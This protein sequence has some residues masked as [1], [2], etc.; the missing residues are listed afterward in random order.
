ME[1]FGGVPQFLDAFGYGPDGDS[2]FGLRGVDNA[3][4]L[5]KQPIGGN[6]VI[7]YPDISN[8]AGPLLRHL[9]VERVQ[10]LDLSDGSVSFNVRHVTGTTSGIWIPFV[11]IAAVYRSA[12][13]G[14]GFKWVVRTTGFLEPTKNAQPRIVYIPLN[15]RPEPY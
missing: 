11:D 4:R 15:S 10:D 6:Y 14:E 5:A 7:E 2:G 9:A 13:E 8:L 12:I 1:V 3:R